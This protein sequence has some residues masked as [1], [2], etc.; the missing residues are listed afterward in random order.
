MEHPG[1]SNCTFKRCIMKNLPNILKFLVLFFIL[2]ILFTLLPFAQPVRTAAVGVYTTFQQGVFNAFHPSIR[3]D[4]RHYEESGSEF[5]YSIYIYDKA[6]YKRTRDKRTARHKFILNQTARLTAFGP[7]TMLL[8]LVLA[9]PISWRRKI[10]SLIIGSLLV[11]I[12]LSMKYTS[13]FDA[14]AESLRYQGFSLWVSLSR[15]LSDAFRTTEFLS[16]LIIPIWA[17]TS[18]RLSDWKWFL[19]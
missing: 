18:L 17:I 9:S 7:F 6:E 5:D 3:T 4:F 11:Y 13:L 8:A 1:P 14:N 10:I 15:Q 19:K 16:I 2:Y 12:L